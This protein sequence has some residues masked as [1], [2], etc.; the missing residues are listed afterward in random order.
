LKA[1]PFTTPLRSRLTKPAWS[2]KP[3]P[4]PFSR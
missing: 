2:S 1:C 4:M 3:A